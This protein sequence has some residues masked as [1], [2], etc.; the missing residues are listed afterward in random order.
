M[1]LASVGARMSPFNHDIASKLQGLMMSLDELD[2][3]IEHR[4]DPDLRRAIET[5]HAAVKEL[6]A[7]LTANRA[8]TRGAKQTR[9]TLREV[10]R[11]AAE[12]AGAQTR[13]EVVA[14]PIECS[15]PA[16]AHAIALVMDVCAGVQRL[17]SIEITSEVGDGFAEVA[18]AINGAPPATA[19]E[20]LAL[21][22]YGLA[23]ERG[24]LHCAPSQIV[25]RM[26]VAG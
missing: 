6:N 20:H 7:L 26:P 19:S 5:A 14:A 10:V 8:L 16:I 13:G 11:Q 18:F 9:T 21:A 3:L 15:I 4:G 17:R 23:R 22:A 2:E 1:A 25:I 24:T 12:R